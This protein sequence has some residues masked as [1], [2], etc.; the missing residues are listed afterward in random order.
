VF[1]AEVSVH[2]QRWRTL[3]LAGGLQGRS[4]ADTTLKLF[5]AGRESGSQ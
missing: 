3:R 5:E 1:L 2:A 4:A